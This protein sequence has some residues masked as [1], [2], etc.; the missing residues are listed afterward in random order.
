MEENEIYETK[1]RN[2]QGSMPQSIMPVI[3]ME[4]VH[5][6]ANEYALEGVKDTLKSFFTGYNS[7][8]T[9]LVREHFESQ[10][11]S[12]NM[13]I[14]GI[15]ALLN[16]ALVSMT[17]QV[18]NQAVAQSYI[19]AVKKLLTRIDDKVKV[20]DIVRK[21]LEVYGDI[22]GWDGDKFEVELTK[23]SRFDWYTL[24]LRS[25]EEEASF[26]ITLHCK[27]EKDN[28]YQILSIPLEE[29]SLNRFGS[30]KV[31]FELE[32]GKTAKME[33]P[34]GSGIILNSFLSYIARIVTFQATVII[35]TTD[36][37]DLLYEYYQD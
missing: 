31:S 12:F 20:S 17:D 19:P 1:D 11:P 5:K 25:T 36:F 32:N 29:N 28:E 27:S 7:P 30:M 2:Q 16:D 23:D 24:Q 26:S 4:E 6:A 15:M 9:K 34:Y 13:D 10:V 33:M 8:F 22:D 37:D 14:T 21:F 18:V 3:D 35:D